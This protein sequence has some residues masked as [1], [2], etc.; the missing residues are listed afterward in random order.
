MRARPSQRR[1][2]RVVAASR[3][4]ASST[5]CGDREPLGPRERA[6]GAVA[7]LEHVPRPHAVALDAER[8]VG[9]RAGSSARRRSR[10]RRAGRRRPASTRPAR[11]RSRR[12]ARRPARPRRWP[13]RH[14]TVRTSMC[15]ASSSAGGRVCGVTSSSWSR[16][17]IVSASRTTT[18]PLGVFQV[19]SRTFVPGIV[20]PRRRVVDPE[21]REPEE[22]GLAIEQAA[23]HARRV[24]ARDAEP[25]DRAVRRDERARV[26]VGEERVL[27]DRR[28]RRRRGRALRAGSAV[29]STARHAVTQGPCQRPWPATSF[30]APP[31]GPTIPARTRA[32]AAARRAAAA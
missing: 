3:A 8:R 7:R 20:R 32:P 13:S 18:Q 27:R 29:G 17:P 9:L 31:P 19:V 4:S 6:E 2:K 30:V 16:G 14:S 11:G 10:R 22:A 28:E 25:V 21:R 12:P 23:E 1:Q 24:E 5:S 15:S 26:A